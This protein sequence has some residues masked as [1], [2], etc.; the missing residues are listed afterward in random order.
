MHS[1]ILVLFS[2]QRVE[3]IT[4]NNSAH[5]CWFLMQARH[6]LLLDEFF[7]WVNVCMCPWFSPYKRGT[8]CCSYKY[9]CAHRYLPWHQLDLDI[10]F[11]KMFSLIK[12]LHGKSTCCKAKSWPP[13][14]LLLLMVL[15]TAKFPFH[16]LG[17]IIWIPK[18]FLE[19]KNASGFIPES[20][21]E[22]CSEKII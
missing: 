10:D 19:N 9:W 14:S 7:E 3:V 17:L 20:H 11:H 16:K 2:L 12:T 21:S 4:T 6:S 13:D 8:H 5:N 1:I 18:S 22:T 15:H